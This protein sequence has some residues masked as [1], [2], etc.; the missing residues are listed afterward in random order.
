[1]YIYLPPEQGKPRPLSLPETPARYRIISTSRVY[2][3]A[4]CRLHK[5]L[6]DFET[7][8]LEFGNIEQYQVADCIGSGRFSAVFRGHSGTDSVA[9]KTFRPVSYDYLKREL[10]FLRL[11]R[12]CPNAIQ[13][14]DLVQDPLSGAISLVTEFVQTAKNR[15]LY[16]QFTLEDVRHYIYQLLLALDAAHSLGIM[17]RDVKPDNMLIDHDQRKLR[18]ID[19]GLAEI[20]FPKQQYPAYVGTLR[21][22]SP[23]L[24][25]GYRYYDYSVDLWAAGVTMGEMLVKYP[26]FEGN[27][28]EDIALELSSLV[29]SAAILEFADQYGIEITEGFLNSL[30][31]AHGTNW[32][33][34]PS[35]MRP[36]MKDPEALDLLQKLLTVNPGKRISAREALDHP[37]FRPLTEA[38]QS[39]RAPSSITI[40]RP[41]LRRGCRFSR[42]RPGVGRSGL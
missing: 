4:G 21:Y 10:F 7:L 27:L 20:Y 32:W 3:D 37:F 29:S 2:P 35:L 23:E 41:I 12:R 6:F 18:L 34:I 5:T 15:K 16:N 11:V 9:I 24:M 42:T 8:K 17:H 1:M 36:D 22:R 19:W 38:A 40:R 14:I 33:K 31:D 30:S 26:F 25:V 28:N 39:A 13:F